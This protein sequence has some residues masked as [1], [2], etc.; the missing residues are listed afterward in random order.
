MES[1]GAALACDPTLSFPAAMETESRL[2][3]LYRFLNN[4]QVDFDA[5]HA[6]HVR[7]TVLRAAADAS[8]LVLHDTT[9]MQFSGSR[10]GLGTTQSRA[11]GFFLH[12]SLL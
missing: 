7:R 2:E 3:A 11:N 9:T 1:I 12:A 4:D 8:V 5:V 6:P 10:E